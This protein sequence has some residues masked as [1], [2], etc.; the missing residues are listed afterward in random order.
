VAYLERY[1]DPA[2]K[3]PEGTTKASITREEVA[4]LN[5][6]H[7]VARAAEEVP[8]RLGA[9]A[10]GDDL[11]ADKRRCKRI[12]HVAAQCIA[13]W[14]GKVSAKLPSDVTKEAATVDW[15]KYSAEQQVWLTNRM[16]FIATW[17][18]VTNG[19]A[20]WA[21]SAIVKLN[22]ELVWLQYALRD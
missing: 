18:S 2:L 3:I 22:N 6:L 7:A 17:Q 16:R 14:G 5:K 15:H 12:A 8:R 19:D 20:R 21:K 11:A 1:L 9:E 10:D 13:S 4:R